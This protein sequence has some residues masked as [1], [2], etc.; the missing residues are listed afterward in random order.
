MLDRA[1]RPQGFFAGISAAVA[2]LRAEDPEPPQEIRAPRG[3]SELSLMLEQ[4][5]AAV[6][7]TPPPI[8]RDA[9]GA[10]FLTARAWSVVAGLAP[11]V[12]A[13]AVL[14]ASEAE[15][16]ADY[17]QYAWA[18]GEAAINAADVHRDLKPEK[19]ADAV[20]RRIVGDARAELDGRF[21]AQ[22]G[23]WASTR[24][25]PTRRHVRC[26]ELLWARAEAGRPNILA[27]GARQWTD[28]QTQDVIHRKALASGDLKKAERN[29]APEVVMARRYASGAKWI[30]PLADAMG[31]V[32]IDPWLLSLLGPEGVD[33]AEA[34]AMLADGRRR[35]RRPAT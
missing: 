25:Q 19:L 32:I 22:G 14:L 24:Q 27:H 13:L 30:G 3:L 35:W 20:V 8:Q 21:A 31:T 9:E 11:P 18:I 23:R 1:E 10:S 5:R 12:G 34:A 7:P 4:V 26:A 6:G 2:R 17:P 28:N 15:P 33:E 16:I 29:P